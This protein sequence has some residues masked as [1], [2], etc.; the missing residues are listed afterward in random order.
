M[1][2]LVTGASG[3]IGQHVVQQLLLNGFEAVGIDSKPLWSGSP[4]IEKF[5]NYIG[6]ICDLDFI[7]GILE[8]N[9]VTGVINLAALKSV[10]ESMASP[11]LYEKVN[12]SGVQNLLSASKSAGV[13]YFIQSSTAAV[14]G[15]SEDGYVDELSPTNPIS[16]YGETKLKAEGALSE[17]MNMGTLRGTS[18]RYFNVI[19]SARPALKDTSTANIV[20]MVLSALAKNQSPKIF[21]DDYSTPDGTC[22]RDYV[23]VMDIAQAH[24]LA[25]QVLISRALP[26]AINIGT[27]KGY[28]VREM[29]HEILKQKGS[30]LVPEVLPRRPGDPS[31]LVARVDLAAQV[32]GFRAE[33]GLE[34][35]IASAI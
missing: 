21:G 15:A 12:Y 26:S 10:E 25:A 31:M 35:M 5:T 17:A 24:V 27:G 23:H 22:V 11:D 34:E 8:T 32:L 7:S 13:N 18:L 6:N 28:S 33:K 19:G 20:P 30:S 3:Y 4:L 14:Y 29:I 1:S 16:P 2:W 9:A